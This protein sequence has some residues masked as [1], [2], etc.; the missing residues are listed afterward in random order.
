MSLETKHPDTVVTASTASAADEETA[1]RKRRTRDWRVVTGVRILIVVVW[2]GLVGDRGPHDHRPVLLLESFRHL[3]EAGHLVH[4]GHLAGL[5]LVEHRDHPRGGRARLRDRHHRRRRARRAA[6]PE[7]LPRRRARPVHQGR[8]R[9]PAHRAG[10]AV[11]DL[12][13]TRAV[14]EGRD[15]VRAR[16]LRGVLQRLPGRPRGRQGPRR[17]RPHP[18]REPPGPAAHDHPAERHLVDPRLDARRL[19]LRPDRCGR[20]RV[21]R[22]RQGHGPADQ[23]VPGQLRRRRA[24]TPGCS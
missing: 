1:P 24:S 22:R 7:L 13:R 9:D 20:R 8:E 10:V 23:Q 3:A 4:R 21:H 18:R 17:Q 14:L 15:R 16:L 5:D 6:R 2:L 12:V 19:R 11:R